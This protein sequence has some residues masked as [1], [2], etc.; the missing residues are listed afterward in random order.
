MAERD[1][2]ES[3]ELSTDLAILYFWRR[4][5]IRERLVNQNLELLLRLRD[6]ELEAPPQIRVTARAL[7]YRQKIIRDK[8]HVRRGNRSSA[9]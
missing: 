6:L 1:Y 2:L 9:L 8:V 3:S 5:R 4:L 7:R